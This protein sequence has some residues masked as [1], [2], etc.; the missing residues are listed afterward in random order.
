MTTFDYFAG[1]LPVLNSRRCQ[2]L[3]N[4]RLATQLC[5]L[6]RR[7][8]RIGA[9]DS[10]S[11]PFGG[12]DDCAAAVAGLMVRLVGTRDY[13]IKSFH[14]PAAGMSRSQLPVDYGSGLPVAVY[15]V[16][17]SV[18]PGAYCPEAGGGMDGQFAWSC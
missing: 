8:S 13:Q 10:I 16:G 2:L 18:K 4:K 15:G 14:M 11:H 6:E 5:S 3:D 7:P 1:F 17:A 9:K 12:H